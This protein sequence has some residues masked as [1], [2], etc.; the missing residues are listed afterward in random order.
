MS[1]EFERGYDAAAIGQL[2]VGEIM[3]ILRLV[4]AQLK[5][6]PVMAHLSPPLMQVLAQLAALQKL[7]IE[8]A[9]ED[10][11]YGE[12]PIYLN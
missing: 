2:T 1:Q 7:A 11:A 10:S 12:K 9:E 8:V 5:N 4:E 6:D 3:M